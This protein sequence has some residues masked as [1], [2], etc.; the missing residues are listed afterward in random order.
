MTPDEANDLLAAR[1]DPAMADPAAAAW[2]A[3]AEASAATA[4]LR[5][6]GP[7]SA[8]DL[9]LVHA[10]TLGYSDLFAFLTADP[11]DP[12]LLGEALLYLLPVRRQW[13]DLMPPAF[14][15]VLAVA[16]G[17]GAAVDGVSVDGADVEQTHAAGLAVLLAFERRRYP[18]AP[19]VAVRLLRHTAAGCPPEGPL[20]GSVLSTLGVALLNDYT[21]RFDASSVAEAVEAGRAAVAAAPSA[22]G[23]QAR[24]HANLGTALRFWSDVTAIDEAVREAVSE[25]RTALALCPPDDPGLTAY[26]VELGMS[27]TRA[28]VL[29]GD[30]AGLPEA[31]TL[32]REAVHVPDRGAPDHSTPDDASTA[33]TGTAGQTDRLSFLGMALI[34]RGTLEDRPA[35]HTEGIALARQAVEAATGPAV[36]L[37]YLCNLALVLLR[38]PAPDDDAGTTALAVATAQEAADLAP[39]G[40]PRFADTRMLLSGTLV[41]RYLEERRPEDLSAAVTRATEAFDATPADLPPRRLDRAVAL[42][43]LLGLRADAGGAD[44]PSAEPI[45]LLRR[46]LRERPQATA[47]RAQA[48]R[49][50]ADAL[51]ESAAREGRPERAAEAV[52]HYRACLDLPSPGPAFEAEVRFALGWALAVRAGREDE[53][54]W[55]QSL[56]SMHRALAL[57]PADDPQRLDLTGRL[58]IHWAQRGE[59]TGDPADYREAVALLSEVTAADAD[60]PAT[61]RA[62]HRYQLG[63]ALLGLADLGIEEDLLDRAVDLLDQALALAPADHP[64]RLPMV[65]RLTDA[66]NSLAWLRSDTAALD[67]SQILLSEALAGP[68]GGRE[69]RVACLIGL[70]TSLRM[71]FQLN[72]EP[73]HLE[74]AVGYYREAIALLAPE[75]QPYALFGLSICLGSLYGFR[76]D[77][78]LRTEAMDTCR[79][80]LEHLPG[81]HPERASVLAGL[82]YLE[83]TLAAES[84]SEEQMDAA[85]DTLKTAVATAPPGYGDRGLVLTNLGAALLDRANRTGDRSWEAQAA[86]VF[87]TALEHTGPT[88]AQRPLVLNNLGMALFTLFT[89]TGDTALH[90]RAIALLSEA[91]DHR[92]GMSTARERAALNLA[93]MRF[94]QARMASDAPASVEACR[95]LEELIGE[96]GSPHPL[97]TLALARLA[98]AGLGTAELLPEHAARTALRRAAAAAREALAEAQDTDQFHALARRV[99]ATAQLRRAELGERVDLAEAVRLLRGNAEDTSLPPHTRLQSAR[100][101]GAVAARTGRDAE[102]LE[103]FAHAVGLLSRVAPRHLDRLDQEE[104][105]SS[106]RG[107]ASSAAALAIR[108][109]DPERALALLEQGRGV[110]LAQGLENQGDLS[111]LRTLD[112]ARAEEFER[113]RDR[114]SRDHPVALQLTG[115]EA[116]DAFFVQGA[117]DAAGSAAGLRDA[118]ERHILSR[119]WDQ[120]LEEIRALPDLDDF[121]RPPTTRELLSVA[122]RGPV[123][124]V[125]VSDYGSHALVLAAPAGGGAR[126]DVVPLPDLTPGEVTVAAQAF[127]E[128]WIDVAYGDEGVARAKELMNLHRSVLT[129]LWDSLA[130]PVLERLGLRG[131][132]LGE[133]EWPRLWWCPT[134]RLAFLPLHAAGK[135]PRIPG[136]WVMDRVVSSY[137]PTLRSLLRARRRAAA[138]PRRRPAPLVVSLA[139]TPGGPPLPGAG[140]E[141]ALVAELFPGGLRLDGEHASVEA[142]RRELYRHPWVHF[143]CHGV[144]D[145]ESPSNSGLILHDGRLSALDIS[146]RRPVDAELAF[147]SACSTSQ[148]GLGLPDEA[149]HLAPSFQLAGF[150]HVIGTLWTVS[151]KVARRLTEEFYAALRRDAAHEG[152]FDPALA[153]HHPVRALRER[154]LPA[155]H[156]WAAHV[157]V[158]P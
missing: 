17:E 145:P 89:T 19:A 83:W 104:R 96:L 52:E 50:L 20:L 107:L 68:D 124:V 92:H 39:A 113:I 99:L 62:D 156:L 79:A 139:Q 23:E 9:P 26:R 143:T 85:L 30:E 158:G 108:A 24:R 36:R 51:V 18:G 100:L 29:A 81:H 40:T 16:A 37:Q 25:G 151:D 157:H 154:L 2:F 76:P 137:T 7:P 33:S 48:Q 82:G 114:L 22:P 54:A 112:P 142:V 150:T 66:L 78:Q 56:A 4:V 63:S 122:E 32:L 1:L 102:A 10:H 75:P 101:W 35:L 123:V 84:G 47:D 77:G 38:F 49:R 3:T 95:R 71:R 111:R 152:P 65:C 14:A 46:L 119:R 118:E 135:G 80:A 149:V 57:L 133:E 44:D 128:R 28:A 98:Y 121:L 106:G 64:R 15:A 21:D 127:T 55:Q 141:A 58:G 153:L 73:A 148:G 116:P 41:R 5:A 140:P 117:A 93:M 12:A 72:G 90:D 115:T 45:A 69:T 53:A 125:N 120:L 131:T 86:A 144:S 94:Q 97:R 130:G 61:D 34:A 126:I 109:G 43:D 136:T 146:A 42:A 105:L 60:R 11:R 70:G 147:L 6:A 13:P 134:G 87:R 129:W 110:L 132:P 103:G 31:A 88:S 27:L 91:A 74:H 8:A 59:D 155:P 67:R 138:S